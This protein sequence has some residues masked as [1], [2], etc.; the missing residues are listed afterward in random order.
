MVLWDPALLAE[1]L[2]EA[3]LAHRVALLAE[4][5]SDVLVLQKGFVLQRR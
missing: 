4:W 1:D 2:P 3:K 5:R